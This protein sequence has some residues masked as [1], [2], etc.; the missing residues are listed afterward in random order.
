M[1]CSFVG[2]LGLRGQGVVQTQPFILSGGRWV[3]GKQ[4]DLGE[5]GT[6]H[7]AEDA[8]QVLIRVRDAGDQGNAHLDISA[9]QPPRIIQNLTVARA[10]PPAV[11]LIVDQFQVVKNQIGI[12][13]QTLKMRPVA[14]ATGLDGRVNAFGATAL[15]NG[16]GE[17]VLDGHLAASER[18]SA[19]GVQEE[20]FEAYG[21]GHDLLGADEVAFERQGAPTGSDR[22]TGRTRCSSCGRGHARTVRPDGRLRD[23]RPGML[24]RRCNARG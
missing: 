8:V 17:L 21:L 12:R 18:D 1:R 15:Q 6:K 23:T 24:R 22:R 3:V 20:G 19:V 4:C 13:Q 7:E 10:R 14:G 2:G 11:L 5:P 9:G 16:G